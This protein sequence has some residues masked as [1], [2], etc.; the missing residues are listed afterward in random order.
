M[1]YAELTAVAAIAVYIVGVSGFTYSWRNAI[2]RRLHIQ[3]E[4][5]RPLKPF[6]CPTCMTWWSCIAYA[7]ITHQ[8]TIWTLLAAAA[9][10]LL[11]VPIQDLMLFL[12]EGLSSLIN[13]IADKL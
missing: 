2:A 12:R 13:K 9:L 4:H 8:F 10:S 11:A 1:I 5:L 3:E 7:A 6:D